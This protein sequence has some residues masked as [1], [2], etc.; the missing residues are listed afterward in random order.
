MLLFK[1]LPAKSLRK[2]DFVT[3]RF[4]RQCYVFLKKMRFILKILFFLYR[5]S[6]SCICG[7]L[8]WHLIFHYYSDGLLMVDFTLSNI[9]R[10]FEI[11]QELILQTKEC[12]IF[13]HWLELLKKECRL[14][15]S[16]RVIN[17]QRELNRGPF[18]N[19]V[20]R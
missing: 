19:Y 5:K 1:S 3:S 7:T 9:V 14:A 18:I 12:K 20:S 6:F 2:N 10:F 16:Y 17:R 11:V 8:Q 15:F 13:L 4:L